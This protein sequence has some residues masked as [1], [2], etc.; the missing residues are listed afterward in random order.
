MSTLANAIDAIPI[1]Q[2]TAERTSLFATPQT[3]QRVHNLETGNIERFDSSLGWVTSALGGVG[4]GEERSTSASDA[5]LWSETLED[6][7]AYWIT[8][9]VVGKLSG[10]AQSGGFTISCL[11]Y[12]NG[13]GAV[14]QDSVVTTVVTA[15]FAGVVAFDAS[16]NDV[17]LRVNSGGTANYDWT[18]YVTVVPMVG[19]LA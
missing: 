7:G 3:N 2:T 9:L 16:G 11:V 12:R 1:V 5:T 6:E 19:E 4:V 10:S 8:A 15:S 17:R 13:S 14:V 18:A